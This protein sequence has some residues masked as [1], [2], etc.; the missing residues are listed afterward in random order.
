MVCAVIAEGGTP[1]EGGG[2]GS[3]KL[4]PGCTAAGFAGAAAAAAPAVAPV[5]DGL[6]VA[7]E[8]ATATGGGVED[9]AGAAGWAGALEAA[10]DASCGAWCV[11]IAC[12]CCSSAARAAA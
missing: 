6:V 11:S 1:P 7:P 10:D 2:T 9:V 12:I 5:A 8:G 3:N 4:F